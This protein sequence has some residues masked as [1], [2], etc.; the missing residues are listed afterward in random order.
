MTNHDEPTRPRTPPTRDRGPAG[1]ASPDDLGAVPFVCNRCGAINGRIAVY[2][3]ALGSMQM[4]PGCR[5]CAGR[6]T[7]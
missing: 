6:R 1:S 7:N 2:L 3:A 5:H 4:I